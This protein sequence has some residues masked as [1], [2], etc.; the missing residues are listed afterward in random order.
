[1]KRISLVLLA[2]ACCGCTDADVSQATAFGTPCKVTV[3]SGGE[4]VKEYR[5]TG[6]VHSEQ[7]T[8]GWYFRDAQTGKLVRVSGTVTIEYE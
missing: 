5:S 7:D 4:A 6:R 1:M 3:W 2:I 8:D